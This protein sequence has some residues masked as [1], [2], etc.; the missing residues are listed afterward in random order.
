MRNTGRKFV[1][2]GRVLSK[3]PRT[4]DLDG[5]GDMAEESRSSGC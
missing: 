1:R 2:F 5:P 3:R 4:G